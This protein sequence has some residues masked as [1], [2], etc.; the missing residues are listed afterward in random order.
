[1]KEFPKHLRRAL[2]PNGNRRAAWHD[3]RQRCIYMITLN[4]AKGIPALAILKGIP[5]NREWPP[6]AEK[7]EVGDIIAANLSA[8]K[9]TYPFIK[10]LRRVIMPDHVHFA[11]FIERSTNIHLGDIINHLKRN[12]THQYATLIASRHSDHAS[13]PISMF[14][15]CYHDRILTKKNQLQKMLDYISDNPRRRLL[16]MMNPGF[17]SRNRI[18]LTDGRELD[19]YGNMDLLSDPDVEPV[20][21]SRKYTPEELRRHKICWKRTIENCGVLVSPFISR[22]EKKVFYWAADNGGRIIYIIDGGIGERF[23]PKGL[24][25]K[26]CDEGRLLIVG[27]TAPSFSKTALSRAHC[28]DMNRIAL[29]ISSGNFRIES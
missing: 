16:R 10:I 9:S 14:E 15:D 21:I 23:T 28:E 22:D 4:A 25:H 18:I 20:R 24:L 26:L 2:I 8:L 12:C 1:M 5:G 13:S 6:V 3:Y 11:I 19:I 29:Y 17:H 7:T 27:S